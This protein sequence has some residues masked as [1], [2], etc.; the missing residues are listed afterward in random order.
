MSQ[1]HK[2]KDHWSAQSYSAAASFVPKLTQKVLQY[3]DPQ[4]TDRVLDLGCGDAKFTGN[5]LHSVA[6]VYGVDAS[7]S[8]I[9]SANQDYGSSKARFTVLD[10]RYLEQDIEAVSG[11]WDKVVSN[12]A[13]HWI[14]RDSSTRVN[15]L[16]ACFS[17][18]KTGGAFV[19]EMGGAGN[20]AEVHTALMS[21]L[22]HQ[23]LSIHQAQ[24]ASPWFFP[25]DVWMRK[26]L[27]DIGF[28]VEVLEVEYRPTKL[29]TG[30][31]G[32]LRGW[33]KLMGASMLGVLEDASKREAALEQVCEVLSTIVTR[34]EDG[35]EWLGY[36]RLRGV[37]RKP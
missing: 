28:I 30:D 12:A 13:L 35:S 23:G 2:D 15:T 16:R 25:S 19:F 10:C 9:A 32:G 3:L 34:I 4:P 5:Y 14:L 1:P 20:V 33:V 27:E 21:A 17:A 37:A 6:E 24:E 11:V 31:E 29:T 22:L 8:L 18:L 36:V 26:T 7:A